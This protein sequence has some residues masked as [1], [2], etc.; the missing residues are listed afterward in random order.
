MAG[1][2][3]N[4]E[5][6]AIRITR[7]LSRQPRVS[8]P[9][10]TVKPA[11][12]K[13]MAPRVGRADGG[14]IDSPAAPFTGPIVGMS[15]GRTDDVPMHVPPG[16]YVV[17]ADIVSHIGDGNSVN[18]LA[19]LKAMFQP[20]PFGASAAPWGA[21]QFKPQ[22][23][24]GV[25]GP[26]MPKQASARVVGFPRFQIGPGAATNVTRPG[27]QPIRF[28]GHVEAPDSGATP[29]M[30]SDGEFVIPP[31]EV[32]RRGG[33]SLNKGH[34]ILDAWVK[35]QRDEHIK[36]LRKLPGPAK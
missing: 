19:V 20:H 28:G 35:S 31:D 15:G 5:P 7:M 30:A 11:G 36:T 3:F 8:L 13:L 6:S 18:G 14:P 25:P 22:M 27:P 26:G 32:K 21:Q 16:S 2:T 10:S 24:A 12:M 9:A 34:K 23:G 4:P 29:I 33:G 1:P 17:P